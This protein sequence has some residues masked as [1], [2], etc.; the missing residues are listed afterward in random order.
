[1]AVLSRRGDTRQ[2]LREAMRPEL[3]RVGVGVTEEACAA[4]MRQHS[5]RHLLVEGG[6][7]VVGLVSMTDLV[8]S[9]IDEREFLIEQ[10]ETYISGTDLPAHEAVHLS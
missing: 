1:M 6:G 5:A 9:M 10:L 8:H 7:R 3:P 2:S 4:A